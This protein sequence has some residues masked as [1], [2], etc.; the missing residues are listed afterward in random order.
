MK[1]RSGVEIN[2]PGATQ[3]T[4][5]STPEPPKVPTAS[6]V[7]GF[8]AE[9]VAAGKTTA[10]KL[11]KTAGAKRQEA[12]RDES[13]D[14]Q[15]TSSATG[16]SK[17][18]RIRLAEET[19]ETDPMTATGST[20][21]ETSATKP[22][23]TWSHKPP[24]KELTGDEVTTMLEQ[25]ESNLSGWKTLSPH[26]APTGSSTSTASAENTLTDE[27]KA[28]NT[29]VEDTVDKINAG[30]VAAYT[31]DVVSAYFVNDQ[32]VGMLVMSNLD[33]PYILQMATHP[34]SKGAGGALIEQAVN[35][36]QS[37]GKE[38]KLKLK[39]LNDAAAMAYEAWGFKRVA[40]GMEL[41]PLDNDKWG[42]QDGEWRLKKYE[43]KPYLSGFGTQEQQD[44]QEQE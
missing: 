29:R 40:T 4:E 33:T 23:V 25:F 1:L 34:G 28:W 7:E 20:S 43:D 26:V 42:R 5:E 24:I 35:K 39:P 12:P 11:R 27:Q 17:A 16:S 3:D 15:A 21:A 31:N 10:S 22:A 8:Q 41:N 9:Q 14:E 2:E 36:S 18:K 13:D 44:Q 32:P 38:G 19:H 6:T 37:W 30:F